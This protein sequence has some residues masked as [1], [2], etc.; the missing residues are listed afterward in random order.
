VDAENVNDFFSGWGNGQS[1]WGLNGAIKIGVDIGRE[2][3]TR[4]TV[5]FG[6]FFYYFKEGLQ[7]MEPYQPI[8][9]DQGEPIYNEATG[10][11]VAVDENG[12]RNPFYPAQKYFGTP[13]IKITFGGM[14]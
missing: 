13:Q 9:N 3:K 2:F 14:W 10:L 7:I 4:T 5:E 1:H 11:P 8:K 12:E 6:Y